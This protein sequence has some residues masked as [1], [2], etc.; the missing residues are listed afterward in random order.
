MRSLYLLFAVPGLMLAQQPILTQNGT[1]NAA[2]LAPPGLP[3]API[4]RG[5]IFTV[6][7]EA[8]GPAASPP[9]AFPLG[10]DLGQVSLSVTQNGVTLAAIPIYVSP[11][12]VNA[13]LPSGAKAGLA[14][15]RVTYQS[16]RSNA[17]PIVIADSAPGIFAVSSGGYGP[18]VVTNFVTAGN[19][20]VNSLE[21]PARRG[22]VV[23]IWATGLGPVTF[24]D[25]VAPTGGDVA[26]TV[27]VTIG[28]RP[29]TKAYAGRSPCCAGLDQVVVTVPDDAPLGC[30]VPVQIKAGSLVSNTVTLAVAAAGATTC[31]DPGNPLS[32]LVRTPG[33]QAFIHVNRA[34]TVE[35]VSTPF[36][37]NGNTDAIYARFYTRPSSP[38]AFDPYLSYPPAGSCLVH[39]TL[40][41]SYYDK[42]LRGALPPSAS[43]SP[44]P[45]LS[46]NTGTETV[47]LFANGRPHYAAAIGGTSNGGLV[48]FNL[49]TPDAK[50]VIDE[51]GANE[52]TLSSVTPAAPAWPQRG[53]LEIIPRN[54]P[55]NLSFTPGD[56]A[57]PTAILLYAYAAVSNSTVEVQCLA[58]PGAT[59]FTVPA[60]TLANLPTTYRVL[61]GSYNSLMIGTLG[62]S[63]PVSFSNGVAASG[64][65]LNSNWLGR[66]VV[67]R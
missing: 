16:Q 46:F 65:L 35:T 56:A 26:A 31:S 50:V 52:R 38:F 34:D 8:L 37:F 9:L 42:T 66:S 14:S 1:F 60:E 47:A 3:N 58:A 39:Q 40:G 27:S 45:K 7:G 18:G 25:N 21:A 11:T 41:D 23:T 30:W 43:L 57:S 10:N 6:F 12:Q 29:A 44:Q 20:P 28:G 48:G 36:A 49:A 64:L 61:D 2:S 59:S 33:T 55:L 24:A 22:Q 62:L 15:L 63:K 19:Q 51:G 53:S 32:T 67:L 17:I 4:S 54:T 5:S 13:I